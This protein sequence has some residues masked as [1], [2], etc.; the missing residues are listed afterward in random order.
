M[1]YV[2]NLA[3]VH[4]GDSENLNRITTQPA[5]NADLVNGGNLEADCILHLPVVKVIADSQQTTQH[6][7]QLIVFQYSRTSCPQVVYFLS[8]DYSR[9]LTYCFS[10]K[11]VNL[12]QRNIFIIIIITIT[13]V[14]LSAIS[15]ESTLS[16]H[17][18]TVKT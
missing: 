13:M 4:S 5:K 18:K 9:Q 2:K 10:T 7:R 14:I 6:D 17:R 11:M 16:F 1:H 12:N 15:P 3:I 8:R